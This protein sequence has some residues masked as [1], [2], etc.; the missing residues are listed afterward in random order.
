M[1]RRSV[2]A[3]SMG[4]LTLGCIPASTLAEVAWPSRPIK[5]IVPYAPGG[6]SDI[7]ARRIGE[8]LGELLGQP[9]VVEN[10]AGGNSGIGASAVANAPADGYTLMFTNDATFVANPVMFRSLP[11]DVQRDFVPVA[12]ATYVPLVLAVAADSPVNSADEL[13][14]YLK[15]KKDVSYGSFGVGSQAHLMGEMLN[16]VVGADM[17]HVPYKGASQA[18]TDLIGKQIQLTFP[19]FPTIQGHVAA[20]TLK[21]LAVSGD[22]RIPLMPKVPTFAEAGLKDVDMGAW[23][24]FLAPAATPRSVV[25]KLNESVNKVLS[26]Q[27]FVEKNMTSQ[28]MRTMESTPAQF[29]SL[30]QSSTID[31][32]AYIKRSG[33]KVD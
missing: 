7:L 30:I 24:G 22:R 19:A 25:S 13:K 32:A 28:G 29:S 4:A 11:Y 1:K 5:I 15:A 16:K 10:K 9:V 6:T 31:A 18:V 17:I 3:A 33:A 12:T 27:A 21:V 26:D 20:G 8:K 14:R 2:L 23:Y